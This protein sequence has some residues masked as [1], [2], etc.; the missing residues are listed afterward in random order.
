M[1]TSFKQW[2]VLK[3]TF[4]LLKS[5]LV[6]KV[7][8]HNL[9]SCSVFSFEHCPLWSRLGRLKLIIKQLFYSHSDGASQVCE[10]ENANS[11]HYSKITGVEILDP[12]LFSSSH[13]SFQYSHL[14]AS[15]EMVIFI[16][17]NYITEGRF[18]AKWRI[19][20]DSF[21]LVHRAQ[22]FP[23]PCR[24]T[25]ACQTDALFTQLMFFNLTKLSI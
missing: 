20:S 14:W 11:N 23:G 6:C 13:Q 10:K 5:S 16:Q 22:K 18:T 2:L 4:C 15:I 21:W 25:P 7:K 9:E 17:L 8:C 3:Q 12:F 24:E 19:G 1:N